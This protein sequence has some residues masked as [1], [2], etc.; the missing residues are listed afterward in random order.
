VVE[1]QARDRL[2][3]AADLSTRDEI[4]ALADELHDV[5][6]LLKIGLQAFIGNGPALVREIVDRDVSVFLDLKMHDIPSTVEHA[7]DEAEKLGVA[8]LTVHATGGPSMLRAASSEKLLIL[9]VTILTSIDDDE[10]RKIG[11]KEDAMSA[12]VRLTQ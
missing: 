8:M 11:F 10:L 6:G 4:L 3:V 2:I 7:I 5:I 9:G 12:A 1:M